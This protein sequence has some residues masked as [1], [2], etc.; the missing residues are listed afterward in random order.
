MIVHD[1]NYELPGTTYGV[2]F[3][4]GCQYAELMEGYVVPFDWAL[5]SRCWTE[6][7]FI[8]F[9]RLFMFSTDIGLNSVTHTHT[10]FF[11]KLLAFCTTKHKILLN[12]NNS[13]LLYVFVFSFK[14]AV[15]YYMHELYI[16]TFGIFYSEWHNALYNSRRKCI[17][18]IHN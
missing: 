7:E 10:N 2:G 3:G 15:Y 1:K 11:F 17:L 14:Y 12:S 8:C 16:H 5:L 9:V 13:N 4:A 6:K 18:Y